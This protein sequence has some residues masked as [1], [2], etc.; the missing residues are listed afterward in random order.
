MPASLFTRF[1]LQQIPDF[2]KVPPPI[3]RF[4][5]VM[6]TQDSPSNLPDS[7]AFQPIVPP[8]RPG[9]SRKD[10]GIRTSRNSQ[11]KTKNGQEEFRTDGSHPQNPRS[12]DDANLTCAT[13]SDI[14]TSDSAMSGMAGAKDTR[15][16]TGREKTGSS[17]DGPIDQQL[18]DQTKDQIRSL[19]NEI[20]ELAE[21]DISRDD[22]FEG[23]LNRTV[24]ALAS[25]GGA[26]WLRDSEDGPIQLNYQINLQNTGL[27][28]NPDAQTR[29]SQLLNKLVAAGEPALIAPWSGSNDPTKPGNPTESLL[30]IAPLT[31]D[32]T[33]VGA[34]EIFQRPGAGP[35][36]QRGYL[37]FLSRMCEI[38][39]SFLRDQQMRSFADQQN[40]WQQLETFIRNVHQGLDPEQ[41]VFTIA[42][43][44][45]RLIGCDRV[46]VAMTQGRRCRIKAVSGLD[47]IERR[48]DQVKRL[49]QLAK[50][51]IA[52]GKPLWY[53]GDDSDLPPQIEK[54]L[55]E[56]VDTSHTRMLGIIP[57]ETAD[58]ADDSESSSSTSDSRTSSTHA[59]SRGSGTPGR[60]SRIL[61]ALVVE[62]L[63]DSRLTEST[64]KRIDVVVDHSRTALTN[65]NEYNSIFLLPLW[66]LLGKLT[67]A[68]RGGNLIKTAVVLGAAGTLGAFMC[69]FPWQFSLSAKGH[70]I[71]EKQHEVFVQVNGVLEEINVPEDPDAIVEREQV[72]ARMLNNDLQAE[73]EYLN[74]ELRRLDQEMLNLDRS[75]N[76]PNLEPLDLLVIDGQYREADAEFDIATERLALKMKDQKNLLIRSPIRGQV[77]NWQLRQ[78]LL[79]RPVTKGQNIMTVFDPDSDWILEIEMPEK[80]VSHLVRAQRQSDEPLTVS[81]T[82]AS[83]PGREFSGT[84]MAL[85]NRLD[86][87]SEEGNSVRV[88][89]AF[90]NADIPA[91]LLRSGTRVTA[92]VNC[93]TESIGYVYFHEL[94]ET[95]HSSFILWF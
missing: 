46:S 95:V 8:V 74:G 70:L 4:G 40:M 88:R 44:G 27:A 53:T 61:G 25:P 18:V 79:R 32:R 1:G 60:R 11:G 47:S 59:R 62:Q 69:L 34:V 57:I 81:F 50:K 55:H 52:T 71:P 37:R 54:K 12:D 77:A 48:A 38:A 83:H 90:D 26:I 80:R 45:R 33:P 49:G 75:R 68:F 65:A 56:Y 22:F 5:K 72:L 31:I 91:D 63:R 43:E 19:V 15:R 24:S 87:H 9:I 89:V 14:A 36:I 39:S 51:V 6:S 58:H 84:V 41:T 76:H 23:F 3:L 7:T 42:N 73:I 10:G 16:K 17:Q 13:K 94:I 92:N 2:A 82:L 67:G 93:G 35:T 85:D 29:H 78:N 20:S 28:D 66:R 21:S 30:V 86:V 64:R